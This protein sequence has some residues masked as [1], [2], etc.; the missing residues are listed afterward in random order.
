[1]MSK[2]FIM[3]ILLGIAVFPKAAAGQ[4]ADG[5]ADMNT[6]IISHT[7]GTVRMSETEIICEVKAVS[8]VEAVKKALKQCV[9]FP[10]SYESWEIQEYSRTGDYAQLENPA[11]FVS[12]MIDFY[13]AEKGTLP[14]NSSGEIHFLVRHFSRGIVIKSTG[15]WGAGAGDAIKA[16][17]A[18]IDCN[19]P[20]TV[21]SKFR[22][23]SEKPPAEKTD[24]CGEWIDA[25]IDGG[26]EE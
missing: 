26:D 4:S 10:D 15:V 7:H 18:D 2:H 3:F 16:Y 22:A 1:M 21:K 11:S 25:V 17:L 23:Y 24:A 6:Y 13:S 8:P 5:E 19:W 9:F 20:V 12:D 14:R